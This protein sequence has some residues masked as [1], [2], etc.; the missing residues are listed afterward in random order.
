M[1]QQSE[2][3]QSDVLEL[4]EIASNMRNGAISR[5][6]TKFCDFNDNIRFASLWQ[7]N[8]QMGSISIRSRSDSDYRPQLGVNGQNY[9]EFVCGTDCATVSAITQS[10]CFIKGVRTNH[11]IRQ[12]GIYGR[13]HPEK[14]VK[15]NNLDHFVCLPIS[16][17]EFPSDYQSSEES[18]QARFFC[19]FYCPIGVKASEVVDV[20]LEILRRCL[21]NMI[22]NNFNER[23]RLVIKKFTRFLSS[24]HDLEDKDLIEELKT[25]C[26]PSDAV[27]LVR[28]SERPGTMVDVVGAKGN[29]YDLP[30]SLAE[31]A[32]RRSGGSGASLV[33]YTFREPEGEQ[34]RRAFL[35]YVPANNGENNRVLFVFCGKRTETPLCADGQ[36]TF[37]DNFS[38]EDELI[39]E[40]VGEHIR[41]FTETALE[42]ERRADVMR[43]VGHETE[44]PIV[45]IR[46]S[47]AN[48]RVDPSNFGLR[49]TIDRIDEAA[50]LA[51]TLVKLN[52]EL[53]S[54]RIKKL[55]DRA[56]IPIEIDTLFNRLKRSLRRHCEDNN[57]QNDNISIGVERDCTYLRLPKTLLAT[58]FI[59]TV[60][61]SIKYGQQG[62]YDSWCSVRVSVVNPGDASTW[63][64]LDVP[65]RKQTAGILFTATDNGIGIPTDKLEDVFSREKRLD[66]PD[67]LPGLGLGL[68][69]VKRVV[70]ALGGV[71]WIQNSQ[72]VNGGNTGFST[73]VFVLL[74]KEFAEI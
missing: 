30:N 50:E 23:R 20:D 2:L 59:N 52:T 53:S 60:S 69:H 19:L 21:G 45:D 43:I 17:N 4:L 6:L 62:Y 28:E 29:E 10:E 38:F 8:R 25:N 63:M 16:D 18:K 48:F 73:R 22:Y 9:Q 31:K 41:A 71:T 66:H 26:L 14:I 13:F 15:Y 36:P 32:W 33:P 58:I 56:S 61:N 44:Q 3:K 40:D 11:S 27:F 70:N 72:T 24:H 49:S 42:R 35:G 54:E 37:I 57:F 65:K 74:P 64:R 47:I 46:N 1:E 55:A 5:L 12:S 7:M 51:L 67:S 39:M 68:Y 34:Q